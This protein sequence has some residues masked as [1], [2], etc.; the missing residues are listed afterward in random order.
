MISA[1]STLRTARG[2]AVLGLLLGCGLVLSAMVLGQALVQVR[3]ADRYVT[4]RGLAEREVPADLAVW[5][6][7]F[8][9]TGGDLES[10]HA[11]VEQATRAIGDYLTEHGFADPDLHASPV[12]I[13]DLRARSASEPLA[14]ERY[15]AEGAVT[16]RST[17]VD[18]VTD[19]VR[20][21]QGL[22]ARGVALRPGYPAGAQYFFTGLSDVKPAMIAEATRDARRAAARFAE[23]SN[24]RVGGIRGASQGYFTIEDRDPFAPQYKRVRV[25]AT[26]EYFL[27]DGPL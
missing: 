19:A 21:A 24:S 3:V 6:I 25:V 15:M 10:V 18:A 12:A 16:L 7:R 4:V 27:A 14:A 1:M 9:V 5:P 23:E 13:S 20:G 22:V 17:R 8:S 2:G 26:V 11:G